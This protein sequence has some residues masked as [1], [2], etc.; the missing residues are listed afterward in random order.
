MA[1]DMAARTQQLV[2]A[3]PHREAL[4]AEDFLVSDS[5]AAAVALV[6]NWPDWPMPAAIIVG[7]AGSGKSHLAHVWQLKSNARIVAAADITVDQIPDYATHPAIVVEDVESLSDQTALFHLLNLVREQRLPVLLTSRHRPGDLNFSLPD[8][9][10]RLKALPLAHI[11]APDENVLRA[12]MIKLFSDRQIAV[13][14]HVIDYLIVRMERSM[15]SA[16]ALVAEIDR[17]S[18]ASKR[19]A[20]RALAASALTALRSD[21]A[22]HDDL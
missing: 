3:L 14:P 18:L 1:I 17:Q 19:S 12:V 22:G 9:L 10:S 5:N 7:P 13:E 2:L 8:L 11:S 6:D 20:T 4:G 15:A 16:V 21:H